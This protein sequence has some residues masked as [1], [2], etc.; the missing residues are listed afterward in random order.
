MVSDIHEVYLTAG[1]GGVGV[2]RNLRLS[3][4]YH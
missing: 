4:S 1:N 2:S 3:R